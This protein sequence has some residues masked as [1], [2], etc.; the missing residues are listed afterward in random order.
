MYV[1]TIVFANGFVGTLRHGDLNQ[2]KEWVELFGSEEG[3]KTCNITEICVQ[4]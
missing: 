1:I 4:A 2:I 3:R